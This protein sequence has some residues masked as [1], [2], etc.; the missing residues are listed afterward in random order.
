V[1]LCPST[2]GSVV[3]QGP[4]KYDHGSSTPL[5]GV[6]PPRLRL[7]ANDEAPA[8]NPA[9][10]ETLQYRTA[11]FAGF[12]SV[13]TRPLSVATFTDVCSIIKRREMKVRSPPGT[14]IG[15]PSSQRAT[16]APPSNEDVIRDKR[17]S[18]REG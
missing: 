18:F 12:E 14:Y 16:Y 6:P 7:A 15:D 2:S 1:P 10:K 5:C 8:T 11:L 3:S 13:K 4:G 17:V 9:T